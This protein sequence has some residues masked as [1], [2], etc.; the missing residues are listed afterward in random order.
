MATVHAVEIPDRH[1]APARNRAEPFDPLVNLQSAIHGKTLPAF[2]LPPKRRR[3]YIFAMKL[4]IPI[5][6]SVFCLLTSL[7][8]AEIK[9]QTIEYKDGDVTLKGFL[10]Y[11]D[12]STAKRPGV[13]VA[14]EWWGETDYPQS[15]A[16]QL[17]EHGYVAL[18]V[19]IYGD[20]KTTEDPK[21]AGEW[22]TPYMQDRGK[23]RS[24]MQ[25]AYDTLKKQPQVEGEKIAAIGYCFGGA[26]ALELARSGADLSAVVSF[27][28]NLTSDQK[29]SP[30]LKPKILVC[31]GADDSFVPA[32]QVIAFIEEMKAAKADYQINVYSNAVHAFTNPKADEHHIPNIAY[33]AEA[34]HRS[35]EAMLALFKECWGK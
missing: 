30:G 18:A 29:A 14:P 34:D 11:D 27:H 31:T 15:R 13:L 2:A 21:Q 23:L 19:D 25:A 3:A 22:M 32:E 20:G 35:F 6:T 8:S 5:L 1:D 24:R 17:A 28:G 10:A 9:T 4:S 7:A 12:A 16:R 26:C 33:N